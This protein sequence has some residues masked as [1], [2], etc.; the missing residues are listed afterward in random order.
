[1]VLVI[2]NIFKLRHTEYQNENQIFSRFLLS[3]CGFVGSG[4]I[5]LIGVTAL[6]QGFWNSFLVEMV[7]FVF[8][9]TAVV[10][11]HYCRDKHLF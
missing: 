5:L 3:S 8:V 9:M 4:L 2:K 6:S 11:N 7:Y 1:V 10:I